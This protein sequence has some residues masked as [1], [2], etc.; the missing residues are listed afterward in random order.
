[1]NWLSTTR[2][3]TFGKTFNL[4]PLVLQSRSYLNDLTTV[5]TA[6]ISVAVVVLS[7]DFMIQTTVTPSYY[8]SYLTEGSYFFIFSGLALG[9]G[10]ITFFTVVPM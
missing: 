1:M 10:L 8:D 5:V 9:T 4:H 3:I 7:V 2:L 6:L